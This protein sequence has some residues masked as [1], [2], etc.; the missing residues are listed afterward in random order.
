[1]GKWTNKDK[2][3]IKEWMFVCQGLLKDAVNRKLVCHVYIPIYSSP[4]AFPLSSFQSTCGISV[5]LSVLEGHVDLPVCF[6]H[7]SN[8]SELSPH[9][10]L[11]PLM[12]QEFGGQG[13]WK[14]HLSKAEAKL[15]PFSLRHLSLGAGPLLCS[16]GRKACLLRGG[17]G[18]LILGVSLS[19]SSWA[20]FHFTSDLM[21]CIL[22][23]A[24]RSH[25]DLHLSF[26]CVLVLKENNCHY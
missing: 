4:C 20:K 26:S 9:S 15:Q 14:E 2:Q 21:S 7:V 17:L 8:N 23:S 6:Y 1:M 18:L 19:K 12:G 25:S 13:V 22:Q 5:S 10:S 11:T 16:P 24:K 3:E